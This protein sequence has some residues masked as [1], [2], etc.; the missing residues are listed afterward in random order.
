M[1]VWLAMHR[2]LRTSR[3]IRLAFDHLAPE[4]TRYAKGGCR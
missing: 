3:R 2:D 1:E 4:L